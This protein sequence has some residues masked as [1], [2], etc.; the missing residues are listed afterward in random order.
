MK[1]ITMC[2]VTFAIGVP[3]VGL[4]GE[5]TD[6]S[7]SNRPGGCPEGVYTCPEEEKKPPA[8]GGL[9]SKPI[10]KSQGPRQARG[11]RD[12]VGTV[13]KKPVTVEEDGAYGSHDAVGAKE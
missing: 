10:R 9:T 12:S 7:M 4:A 2:V 13:Y 6:E 5:G 8:G 1:S 11:T 3:V